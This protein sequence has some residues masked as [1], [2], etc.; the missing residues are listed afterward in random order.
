ML[1]NLWLISAQQTLSHYRYLGFEH[2]SSIC[3]GKKHWVLQNNLKTWT[4]NKVNTSEQY[5][6]MICYIYI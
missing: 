1:A 4:D 2:L 5:F 6:A 3:H